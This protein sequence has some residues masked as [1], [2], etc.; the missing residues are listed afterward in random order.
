MNCASKPG[1]LEL[2]CPISA[3]AK[4]QNDPL[5]SEAPQLPPS[6]FRDCESAPRDEILSRSSGDG[7]LS[8]NG[9]AQF[10][11]QD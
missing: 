9:T 1:R 2:N 10:Q 8:G 4:S 6:P 11:L 7:R 5:L 3:A